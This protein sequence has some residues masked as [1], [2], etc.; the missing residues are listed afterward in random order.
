LNQAHGATTLFA[1]LNVLDG[2]VIGRDAQRHRHREF[3]CFLN[4][5]EARVPGGRVV[6][7][8]VDK[9]ATHKH[10]KVRKWAAAHPRWTFHSTRTSCSWLNVI[11]GF[12]AILT[13]RR[14][15]RGVFR[16]VV[17][18]QAAI[19]RVLDE[20]NVE[21]ALQM[22][23]GPRRD[24]RRRQAPASTVRYDPLPSARHGGGVKHR[25]AGWK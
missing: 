5:V 18:L 14:L 22:D 10:P 11:E 16:S 8:I 23:R 7:A 20:H 4:T 19:S 15:K 2:T 3:T 12:F 1:A 13:K 25:A 21:Q 17:D 9:Y 24:H 6:H